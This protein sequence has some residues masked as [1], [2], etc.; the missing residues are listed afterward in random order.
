MG[1][2]DA[3][4][5]TTGELADAR[6]SANVSLL[7][8][9]TVDFASGTLAW[10]GGSAIADSDEVARLSQANT[11]LNGQTIQRNTFSFLD[12]S[13]PSGGASTDLLRF[14]WDGDELRVRNLT[15]GDMVSITDSVVNVPT[16]ELQYGGIEVGFRGAPQNAQAGNYTLVIGDAGKTIYKASGGAGET[17]TIPANASVAFDVGTIIRIVNNGGGDLSIAIT[18]DTLSRAGDGTTG[19][20]TLADHGIAVIEKVASTE[21]FISG[22]GLS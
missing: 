11:F 3:A 19:T 18:T 4:N 8:A 15:T 16:A 6:L 22:V 9:A 14:Q 7:D 17:I 2:N 20:R 13:V 12:F 5:L 10:G 21:W 1:A